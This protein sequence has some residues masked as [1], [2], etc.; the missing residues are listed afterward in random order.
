M[1]YDQ[2]WEIVIVVIGAFVVVA[3]S[4]QGG[5]RIMK[6][7]RR[8][9]TELSRMEKKINMLRLQESRRLMME[10]KANSEAEIDPA[11]AWPKPDSDAVRPDDVAPIVAQYYP[12][13]TARDEEALRAPAHCDGPSH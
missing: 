7:V 5:I 13:P 2:L 9:E 4:L 10:L 1:L 6:S 3:A 8:L 12:R 11:V